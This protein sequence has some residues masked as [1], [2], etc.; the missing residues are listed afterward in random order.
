MVSV[1]TES[2]LLVWAPDELVSGQVNCKSNSD[3][4]HE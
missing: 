3:Q 2:F 4:G 1:L